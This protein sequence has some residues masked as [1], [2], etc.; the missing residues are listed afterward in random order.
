MI[1]RSHLRAALLPTPDSYTSWDK[2]FQALADACRATDVS[3]GTR[4]PKPNCS[5]LRCHPANAGAS[6]AV[7]VK[8]ILCRRARLLKATVDG[9]WTRRDQW[10]HQVEREVQIA[11]LKQLIAS[12][13][14]FVMLVAVAMGGPLEEGLA[15]ISRGNYEAALR[16]LR[17][18]AEQ[19]DAK[20]QFFLGFMYDVGKGA[21]QDSAAAASWYRLAAE[22]GETIAQF[23]LGLSYAKGQGVPQDFVLAHMWLNLAA[24]QGNAEAVKHR[25][26]AAGFM[27]PNQLAEASRLAQEWK[28]KRSK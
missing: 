23:T 22:Q 17:L 27:T 1:K 3:L 13:G 15:A 7:C 5:K 20:A 14:A 6:E 24:A 10:Q 2:C 19:G 21:P 28:P 9:L 12:V 25:D 18:P 26:N 11:M 16:L 4:T 8:N